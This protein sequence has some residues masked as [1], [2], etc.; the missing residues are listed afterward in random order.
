MCVYKKNMNELSQ[1]LLEIQVLKASLTGGTPFKEH[2][3][4]AW[5][6]RE[7]NWPGDLK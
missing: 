5:K 7:L 3:W 1:K 6:V 2:R 4:D